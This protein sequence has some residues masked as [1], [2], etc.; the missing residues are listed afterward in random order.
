MVEAT[1]AQKSHLLEVMWLDGTELGTGLFSLSVALL[2]LR[3]GRATES[4]V[5]AL[6]LPGFNSW[7]CYFLDLGLRAS[8]CPVCLSCV[9]CEMEEVIAIAPASQ[10]CREV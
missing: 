9:T 8:H 4:V 1:E 10:D 7:L 2:S 3:R 5:F 6:R